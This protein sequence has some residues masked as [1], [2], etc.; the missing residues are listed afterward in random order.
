MVLVL[1]PRL[2]VWAR[3]SVAV[4]HEVSRL[5]VMVFPKG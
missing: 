3:H 4:N 2:A 5:S 1:S